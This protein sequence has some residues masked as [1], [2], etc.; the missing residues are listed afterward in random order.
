MPTVVPC[1][2]QTRKLPAPA[3][4]SAPVSD[5][6]TPHPKTPH[7]KPAPP[8]AW[9]ATTYFAEGFPYAVVVNL[10]ELF[11]VA[12]KATLQAVGLTSLFHLPWNLKAF[13][14]PFLD[15]YGTKRK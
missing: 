9:V 1:G 5:A 4:R 3:L 13:A 7:P 6:T 8:G 15:A 10:A 11:F 14:G 2:G 12:Q